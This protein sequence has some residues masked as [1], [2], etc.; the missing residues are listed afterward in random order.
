MNHFNKFVDFWDDKTE[1]QAVQDS[2]KSPRM[3]QYYV[4]AQES[5][6]DKNTIGNKSFLVEWMPCLNETRVEIIDE[7]RPSEK[8]EDS[9]QTSGALR[10]LCQLFQ[11]SER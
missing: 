11:C 9:K 10:N 7:S 4:F 1:L 2:L 6:G 8:I 3:P 5:G